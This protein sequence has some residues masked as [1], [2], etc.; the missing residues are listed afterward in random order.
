MTTDDRIAAI[1]VAYN[2]GDDL[3]ACLGSLLAQTARNLEVIVVDNASTDGS[4]ERAETE[5]AVR[6][7]VIRR[8]TNGGY[9]AGANTGWRATDAPI[10]AILNQDLT[11]EPSCLDEMRRVLLAEPRDALVTPKLVL[12][13]D[14][15]RVNAIGNDVHLSGVA[16]CHGLGTPANDW[17]GVV[18]VTAVSGAAFMA[19]RDHLDRLDGLEEAYFMYMEDVDLSLRARL[20]GAVCLVA[21][22]AVAKH[23]WSLSLTPEKF[24]LLERNR[25]IMWRRLFGRGGRRAEVVLLQAEALGWLYAVSRGR[26]HVAAKARGGHAARPASYLQV[27]RT[28]ARRLAGE[29]AARLPYSTVIPGVPLVALA[30]GIIDRAVVRIAHMSHE[31]QPKGRGPIQEAG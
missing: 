24:G 25:R 30:G 26:A 8:S 28:A 27:D 15:T 5:F 22:D 29:L 16:W 6:V 11:F 19:K 18:E 17:Q 10:V 7:R 9:A 2:G 1:V 4:I 12:K 14:P 20:A 13:S 23:R 21:C 31:R 3:L